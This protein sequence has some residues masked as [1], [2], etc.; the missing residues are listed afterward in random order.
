M[1]S[2]DID[3]LKQ[4]QAL[5]AGGEDSYRTM[6]THTA[7]V[8]PCFPGLTCPCLNQVHVILVGFKQRSDVTPINQGVSMQALQRE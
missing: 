4:L 2:E 6:H 7:R 1:E 5:P 8:G 3:V